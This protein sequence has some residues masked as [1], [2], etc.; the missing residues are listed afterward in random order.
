MEG[1]RTLKTPN[2]SIASAALSRLGP[3]RIFNGTFCQLSSRWPAYLRGERPNAFLP[4]FS[5]GALMDIGCYAVYAVVAL[6]GRCISSYL[7]A[8]I[9]K[10]D[11]L[12]VLVQ[13]RQRVVYANHAPDWS[14]RRWHA[15]ATVQGCDRHAGKLICC[16][17]DGEERRVIVIRS[18]DTCTLVFSKGTIRCTH[19]SNSEPPQ[20]PELY[21][22]AC[23]LAHQLRA[24]AVQDDSRICRGRNADRDRH[25]LCEPSR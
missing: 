21:V 6:L 16:A 15:G 5:N 24:G 10:I 7:A 4:E 8:H 1:M 2:F 20:R 11:V 9:R 3:L 14:R 17:F 18:D 22:G 25:C 19:P 12:W 13:S 23:S